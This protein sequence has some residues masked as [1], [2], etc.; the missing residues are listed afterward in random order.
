MRCTV[1]EV[2]NISVI[3]SEPRHFYLLITTET[4]IVQ[5]AVN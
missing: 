3:F 1:I 5:R 2:S 4:R